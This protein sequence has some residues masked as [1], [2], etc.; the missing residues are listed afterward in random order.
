MTIRRGEVWLAALDPTVGGEIQ[1]TRPV[2]VVSNDINNAHNSV[3]SVI[4]L[5]SNVTR[6]LSFEV[7]IPAGVGGLTK[8][9]KA[10]AD[11]IRTI[12]K[13]R[14]VKRYGALPTSYVQQLNGALKLHLAIP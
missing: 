1:K 9:S 13:S 8:E 14:L 7:H 11:Q 3:V 2:I 6:V 10:K 5:T 4:P 12:D